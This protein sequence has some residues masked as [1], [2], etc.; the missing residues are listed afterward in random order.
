MS[1]NCRS[2][3]IA[4]GD[5]CHTEILQLVKQSVEFMHSRTHVS[6]PPG[7]HRH[8]RLD[9]KLLP[10][11]VARGVIFAWRRENDAA[12]RCDESLECAHSICRVDFR[13]ARHAHR[14]YEVTDVD[15]DM[16]GST[17]DGGPLGRSEER[18]VVSE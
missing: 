14:R 13:T 10:V 1:A 8:T 18:L 15:N 9:C 3:H 17:F 4:D 2:Q 7:S 16:A 11:D 6:T 5:R 12:V